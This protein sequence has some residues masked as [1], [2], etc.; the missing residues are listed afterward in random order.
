MKEKGKLERD[1]QGKIKNLDNMITD[2]KTA[3][4]N[5]FEAAADP[6]GGFV[7]VPNKQPK[8]SNAET[9]PQ[10]MQDALKEYYKK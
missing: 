2:L 5:H 4:P 8:N 1:E 9:E 10:T 6:D 3:L 7:I